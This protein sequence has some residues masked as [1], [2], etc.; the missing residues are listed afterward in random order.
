VP[1]AK[2][3]NYICQR[4]GQTMNQLNDSAYVTFY[5]MQSLGNDF[6]VVNALQN[7]CPI[8][9]E[10]VPALAN[11]HTG[12]GFDQLLIIEKAA[13]ADILMRIINADGSEAKQCGNGL[14][15]IA[16]LV[17]EQGWLQDKRINIA[18][19]AGI[20]SVT[21]HDYDNI[22]ATMGFPIQS[23]G[24]LMNDNNHWQTHISLG[25][26]H[27]ICF[28]D[29]ITEE[30]IGKALS[31][32]NPMLDNISDG[33]NLGFMQIIDPHHIRLKTLERGVGFTHACGSNASAAVAAGI[34]A[35]KLKSPVDVE[36]AYGKLVV[37][38]PDTHQP[39]SLQ[40]PADHVYNGS[41]E[42]TTEQD[43]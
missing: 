21:I 32:L 16:R 14:R 6:M 25:N 29:D 19:H 22:V 28:M 20:Y 36:L 15:C 34:L 40:G 41:I 7:P 43:S 23:S 10:M 30:A 11:R 39:L 8:T 38:W 3:E 1:A 31:E 18:T 35:A 37:H 12:V 13:N 4:I 9:I 27:L 26:D 42:I 33:I 17:H 24:I 2:P 5:K